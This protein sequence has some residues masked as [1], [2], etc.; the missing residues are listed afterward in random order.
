MKTK[1]NQSLAVT[2]IMLLMV[3]IGFNTNASEKMNLENKTAGTVV[4]IAISN[5]DFSLL[6]EAVS[7]AGLV[8]AL[9]SD[10][11]FT[12]FAPTNDAFTN[13]FAKLGINGIADLTVD[14]LMPI[15]T[16]HVVSGEVKST[17]LSNGMVNTLNEN[18][19]LKVDL[20]DGVKINTSNVIAADIQGK[21]G[22]IHVIDAVLLP[23]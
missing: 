19:Q 22:I 1:V 11:P 4:D 2:V 14:Q 9:S 7:K 3:G 13:L 10:G 17:D 18:N 20:A 16:Y 8:E 12:V 5:P 21:N 23:Q 6:V 15:L